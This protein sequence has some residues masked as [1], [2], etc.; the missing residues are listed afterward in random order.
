MNKIYRS[1]KNTK[2]GEE[3]KKEHVARERFNPS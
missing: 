2:Q 1:F 3:I